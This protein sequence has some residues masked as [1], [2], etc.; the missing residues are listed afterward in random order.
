MERNKILWHAVDI[1]GTL[2][3]ETCWDEYDMLNAT[4]DQEMVDLVRSWYKQYHH[5]VIHTSRQ[6]RFCEVTVEWLKR[7]N[8]PFHSICM[9]KLPADDYL[10]D[11]SINPS[12]MRAE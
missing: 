12:S 1:D 9:E 8:I 6:W 3:K 4:P 5:I 2:T 10:D 7:N 11:K